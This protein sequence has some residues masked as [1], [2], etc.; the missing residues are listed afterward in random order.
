MRNPLIHRGYFREIFRQLR[1][2]GLVGTFLLAT[3]NMICF[4]AFITAEPVNSTVSH[5]DPRLMALPMLLFLYLMVPIM[6]FGAY[7]WLNKR[8]ESDFYHAI[9][10]TRVQLYATTAAAIFSWILIA[11]GSYAVVQVILFTAF[12]RPINYL[13]Y[14]CVFLNMLLASIEIVAAFSIGSALCGRRFTAFFQSVA[15]LFLPR[16][17]LTSFWILTEFDSGFTLPFSRLPFFFNPEFNIAATPLHSLIYGINFANV[18]A[19]LWSLFYGAALLVL[20]GVAFKKRRSE[21]AETPYASKVLQTATRVMFGMPSLTLIT[22]LLN[23]YLRYGNDEEFLPFSMSVSLIVAS[24]VFSFLFYCLY[25]LISSRKMKKVVR[26]MPGYVLCIA[27]SLIYIFTPA[28]IGGMRMMQPIACEDIVSYRFTDESTLIVPANI[29]GSEAYPNYLLHHHTF[30]DANAKKLIADISKENAEYRKL[31]PAFNMM[32][33]ERV[34]VSNGRLGGAV[35]PMS[36]YTSYF[37]DG[38][39]SWQKIMRTCLN[40]EAFAAKLYA[41]PKGYITYSSYILTQ[42]E[43]N[44]VGKLLRKDYEALND[45]QRMSLV[46]TSNT[47]FTIGRNADTVDLGLQLYGSCGTENYTISYRINELTPNA[48]RAMLDAVNARQ[49]SEKAV[50]DLLRDVVRWMER[51]DSESAFDWF[52]IGGQSISIW[53]LWTR[54]DR[55]AFATPKEAHPAEY[56]I[57][58]ALSEAPLTNDAAHCA[59]VSVTQRDTDDLANLLR[60]RTVGFAVDD[61]LKAQILLWINGEKPEP[62]SVAYYDSI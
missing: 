17:L 42:S 31:D 15:I 48:A 16:I 55:E 24:I 44:E 32:A 47:V 59:T 51:P 36:E 49:G 6:V 13:L 37:Y 14:L 1:A 33:T 21:S 3:L 50:R 40:D 4:T 57:L 56:R 7:R 20:G 25:E 30:N 35:V 12:G 58:K 11:L 27:L 60:N 22:V 39:N 10:L 34:L 43:A 18:W 41:Y 23:I 8:R 2:K 28:W 26:A 19:M 53:D 61:N 54:E 45:E 46:Y 29:E 38:M 5:F 52:S 9:A 62:E